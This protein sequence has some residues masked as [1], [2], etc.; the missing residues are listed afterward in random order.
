MFTP[1]V[2]QGGTG[3]AEAGNTTTPAAAEAD[4]GA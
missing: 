3:G 2:C 4:A 1:S